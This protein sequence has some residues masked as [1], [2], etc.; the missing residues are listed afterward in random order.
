MSRWLA[1]VA[2]LA[3]CKK[4][5]QPAEDD[6][7]AGAI[8]LG[9]AIDVTFAVPL[10]CHPDREMVI[11]TA[12]ELHATCLGSGAPI[13][14]AKEELHVA[15]RTLSP[16]Q[17]G[18]LAF[19]DGKTLTIVTQ[20]MAPCPGAPPPYP[21]PLPFAYRLPVGTT[22]ATAEATCAVPNSCP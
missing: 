9:S 12:D 2:L 11:H 3:T 17:V 13:D 10:G 8:G 22:R 16:A 20:G 6:C 15:I 21:T 5:R 7:T 1:I 4:S 14:F 18:Y 19:D